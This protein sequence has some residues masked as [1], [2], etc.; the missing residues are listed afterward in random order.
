MN[1]GDAGRY[2]GI[3]LII[4][5]FLLMQI[6]EKYL[7]KQFSIEVSI[8]EDHKLIQ[9]GPYS[10]IRHPRYLG[11]VLFFIGFSFIFQ[12]LIAICLVV[13]LSFVL[14]WRIFTEEA[15][16]RQKFGE[17]WDEYCKKTWRICP[18]VF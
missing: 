6:A 2:F 18:F 16:M 9:T 15:L 5:G 4:P 11:I 10:L 17:E 12:S 1:L 3:I 7:G 13:A 14:I 8:Q